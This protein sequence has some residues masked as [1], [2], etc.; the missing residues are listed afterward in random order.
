MSKR[1]V[2]AFAVVLALALCACSSG[3]SSAGQQASSAQA[4]S[5]AAQS[6]S[7]EAQVSRTSVTADTVFG[8]ATAY[9][10]KGAN[11]QKLGTVGVFSA[12]LSDC[13]VENLEKWCNQCVRWGIYSWCVVKYSDKPGYGVHATENMVDVGVKIAADYSVEDDSE[14]ESYV[15]SA[16][17]VV[18]DGHLAKMGA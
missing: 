1:I 18:Q 12:K 11:G 2:V 6:A 17:S 7:S 5:Q 9:D 10:V 14:A 8:Y 3:T 13:T 16:D 4:S 15:F